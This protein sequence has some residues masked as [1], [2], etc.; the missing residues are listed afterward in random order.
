[1]DEH[2]A[3]NVRIVE[4]P[5]RFSVLFQRAQG[6]PDP[7][8]VEFT[9]DEI[10]TGETEQQTARA[11]RYTPPSEPAEGSYQDF[12]RALGHELDGVP[13]YDLLI[14][15]VGDGTVLVSYQYLDPSVGYVWKKTVATMD[16]RE[17]SDLLK[18][19]R[20]RRREEERPGGLRGWLRG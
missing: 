8:H 16:T 14:D 2:A 11:R 19:A 9:F 4:V 1:V 18:L 20:G 10:V 17:R 15:D 12:L 5:D 7:V 3:R 6:N 13:A